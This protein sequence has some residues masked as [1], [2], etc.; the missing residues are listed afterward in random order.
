LYEGGV[1][2][3]IPSSKDKVTQSLKKAAARTILFIDGFLEK[4]HAC[5][6]Q[7]TLKRSTLK[8]ANWI[9]LALEGAGLVH[10]IF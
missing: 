9:R 6:W 1:L 2:R 3:K 4:S 8:P 10:H 7:G 5:V